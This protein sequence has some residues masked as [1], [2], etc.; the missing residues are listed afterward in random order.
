MKRVVKQIV[1]LCNAIYVDDNCMHCVVTHI[2][3]SLPLTHKALVVFC[4]S[5]AQGKTFCWR[6]LSFTQTPVAESYISP[7][8]REAFLQRQCNSYLPPSGLIPTS[9]ESPQPVI[10]PFGWWSNVI[11]S[12]GHLSFTMNAWETYVTLKRKS[13]NLSRLCG[14]V[15][16]TG[17]KKYIGLPLA[18]TPNLLRSV[19]RYLFLYCI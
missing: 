11:F 13:H 10:H 6:H 4:L 15:H 3:L 8:K 16:C 2:D 5:N 9:H 1:V 19:F 14:K 17:P 18:K 7:W 12:N